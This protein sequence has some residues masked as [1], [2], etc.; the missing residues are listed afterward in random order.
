MVYF[1]FYFKPSIIIRPRTF[2]FY[3]QSWIICLPPYFYICCRDRMPLVIHNPITNICFCAL[4]KL[5]PPVR[6]R[7]TKKR[8]EN[9]QQ[10]AAVRL[11]HNHF[12]PSIMVSFQN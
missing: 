6:L 9:R 3:Y 7:V 8:T 4:Q 11:L 2:L 5:S 10:N 1:S 12:L